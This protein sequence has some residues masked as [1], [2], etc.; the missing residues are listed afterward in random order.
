M[1]KLLL[2]ASLLGAFLGSMLIASAAVSTFRVVQTRP[3][4]LY[5]GE[6]SAA[7]SMRITPFPLDLDGTKFTMTDFGS[8]PTVTVDPGLRGIEEIESFTG[9]TD[10]GD[11]TATLT[12]L[13]RDLLSKYPYTTA[14]TGRTHG[15]GAY[16]VFGNNPQVYGRL[17]APENDQSWTGTQTFASTT[18]PRY[19]VSPSNTQWASAPGTQLVNLDKLNSYFVTGCANAS[20]LALGCVELATGKEAASSTLIG[21]SG[22]RLVLPASLA[23]SSPSFSATSTIVMTQ[24]DG[25]I[26][27]AFFSTSTAVTYTLGNLTVNGG[28][29]AAAS[30]TFVGTTTIAASNASTSALVLNGL[31]YQM[32]SMRGASSTVPEENGYGHITYEF[33]DWRL[34]ASTSTIAAFASTTVMNIPAATDLRVVIEIANVGAVQVYNMQFNGDT[35]ASY[36]WSETTSGG[37]ATTDQGSVMRLMN[38]NANGLVAQFNISNSPTRFKTVQGTETGLNGGSAGLNYTFWGGWTNVSTQ[39]TSI[40]LGCAPVA[41]PAGTLIRVYGSNI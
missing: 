35:T 9:I 10:N 24:L 8:N 41:C 40:T 26:S 18:A 7:V 1:K 29:L 6:A 36:W 22:A 30:S 38:A 28:V 37:V 15:A 2:A 19:D 5:S 17:A 4:N 31:P 20:E 23:T 25:R 3:Y 21:G 11:G 33:Q 12:G 13:S 32:P 27:P 16:V 14:G 39:I 34:L